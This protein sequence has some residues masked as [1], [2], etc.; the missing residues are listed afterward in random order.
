M[1]NTASKTRCRQASSDHT[2]PDLSWLIGG[3]EMGERIRTLDWSKTPLGPIEQWPQS[4][5]T[6]VSTSL[7]CAFPIVL[8]WGSELVLVYNDE[9]RPV[10]GAKHPAALGQPVAKAWAG[11]WDVIGPMLNHVMQHGDA[12]RSR[13]LLLMM[14]RHGYP[15]ETYFS[16]SYSPIQA[17]N[18]RVGGVFCPCIET[19]D[20]VIGERRLRTLR[21]LGSACQG[22]ESES[23]AFH[24][25]ASVLAANPHDIPFAILYR[26]D[27]S[28]EAAQ[29]E[30][31]VGIDAGSSAVQQS[32]PVSTEVHDTRQSWPIGTVVKTGKPAIVTDLAT[33]FSGM[34]NGAW[35]I[36]PHSAVVYPILLPGHER[37]RAILVAAVSPV[38]ALD[39]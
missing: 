34:P 37:P 8:L 29:L 19:T 23:A 26:I 14:V 1:E 13:D 2:E 24:S 35:K 18:G 3:G 9:Y 6:S 22:S 31:A 15:E 11:I 39:E 16:F 33:R 36:P 12:T 25:A 7:G 4:L 38:R 30:L 20:K 32:L 17:E 28:Q 5:K 21:D 10:L 27:E